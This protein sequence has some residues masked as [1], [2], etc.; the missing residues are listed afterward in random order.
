MV[1]FY[2]RNGAGD[3]LAR[4]SFVEPLLAG[5]RVLELGAARATEGA[6]AL[7]LA[8]RGAAAILSLEPDEAALAATREASHP[9]VQFRAASPEELR[10]GA[11]D[12]VLLADGAEL[13]RDPALAAALRR[14]LGP[15]GRLVTAIPVPGAGALADLAGEPEPAEAPPAYE[16]FAEI[17][18]GA[19]PSVEVATQSAAVGW[20]VALGADD[21]ADLTIDGALAGAPEAAYYVAICGDEPSGLA[22]LAL[23]TLPPRPLLE[24]AAAR[25]GDQEGE[26][27]ARLAAERD[28]AGAEVERLG[29]LLAEARDER[30]RATLGATA[31][32]MELQDVRAAL[33]DARAEAAQARGDAEGA[34]AELAEARAEGDA[35][36]ADAAA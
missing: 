6:S 3:L 31:A 2:A 11:F 35:A 5:K 14:L 33:E 25:R 9:F 27:L 32:A 8:E 30:E 21:D 18:A 15:G 28:E 34:A 10:A 24:A 12:L 13:V 36:R 17:L 19:F 20:V 1:S 26:A 16:P 22:G 4:Y 29:A 7:F 23:V